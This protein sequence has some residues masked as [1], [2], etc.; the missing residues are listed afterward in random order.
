[1]VVS[2]I[3]ED[4]LSHDYLLTSMERSHVTQMLSDGK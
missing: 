3:E 2:K 1:V 4:E